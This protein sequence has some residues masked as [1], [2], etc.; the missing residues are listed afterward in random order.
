MLMNLM[1]N[2]NT[3]KLRN[4]PI[5]AQFLKQLL[6]SKHLGIS[7]YS[8]HSLQYNSWQRVA[9]VQIGKATDPSLG[10]Y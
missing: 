5:T 6:Y 8:G 10:I 3:F 7:G 2:L 1:V 4:Q 9:S